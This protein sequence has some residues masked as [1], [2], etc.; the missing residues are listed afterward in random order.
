[1]E[2]SIE[3]HKLPYETHSL[4]DVKFFG[5]KI[6]TLLAL[7]SSGDP[8]LGRRFDNP[9]ATLQLTAGNDCL[10]FQLLYCPTGIPQSLC[11]F[12]SNTTYTFVGVGI[13]NDAKKLMDDHGLRVGNAVDLRGLAAEKLGDLKWKNSGIK[14]LAREVLGKGVEKPK[15]ITLSRWDNAWLYC[16]SSSICLSRCL[17]VLEDW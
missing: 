17:F 4:Y 2:I 3:D 8:T 10:I 5:D 16:C 12:L 9:V 15:R 13:E 1:M 11:A 7:T 14:G 6:R